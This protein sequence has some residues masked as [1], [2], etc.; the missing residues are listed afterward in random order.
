M[1]REGG[2]AFYHSGEE[3][4]GRSF[5]QNTDGTFSCIKFGVDNCR[6]QAR[7]FL[8]LTPQI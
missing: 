8:S 1:V 6:A 7:T 4:G 5:G 3:A 2:I